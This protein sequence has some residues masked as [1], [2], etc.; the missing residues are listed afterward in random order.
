MTKNFLLAASALSV[1]AFAGAASAH[2]LTYRDNGGGVVGAIDATDTG[3][4]A[5]PYS[6][7]QEASTISPASAVFL[8]ADTL[9]GGSSLPSGN[10]LL[11]I[12]V[13]GGTFQGAVTGGNITADPVACPTFTATISSGG[14]TGSNTVTYI[15]SNSSAGCSAFNLNLPIRP[16][17][18]SPVS[19]TTVLETEAGTPID[20]RVSTLQIVDRP[21][22][23]DVVIDS[24]INSPL[25]GGGALGDTFATL[26]VL[27]VYTT[28]F[29]GPNGHTTAPETATVG[30][31]GTIQLTVDTTA[32]R[33]LA[34]NSVAATDV[35][36]T[37]TTV[38]G[39]WTAFDGAG[40]DVELGGASATSIVGTT[41][42]F[43]DTASPVALTSGPLAFVVTRE[44]AATA[45][46]TSNYEATVD[47]TLDAAF[48]NQEGPV[49]GALE[50]IGRDGTNVVFPWLNDSTVSGQSGTTNRIRLGNVSGVAAGP[51]YA[52]VLNSSAGLPS[53][54][55]VQIAPGIPAGGEVR[56]STADLTAA[57]GNFGRGDVRISVEAPA[58]A[59]TARRYLQTANGGITELSSG[60]VASDQTPAD[61]SDVE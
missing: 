34:L 6:L 47:Y 31:L 41:A 5:E 55:P 48:Y 7:A 22:A 20:G 8:L 51:V 42:T 25:A 40:G 58:T 57:L 9:S 21:S 33:D 19:V 23:F 24:A 27:P 30:Q 14:A 44:T 11:N 45:I 2:E 13:A 59:I 54:A 1:L 17:T 29:V 52:E 43:E 16:N 12:T 46:P 15:I 49:V 28:F 10:V 32:Y 60:T 37:T 4:T 50:R 56:I 38:V 35:V 3:G 39:N 53:A 36:E 61:L 18:A 26:T